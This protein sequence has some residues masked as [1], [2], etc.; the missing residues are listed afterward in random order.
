MN[1]DTWAFDTHAR[2]QDGRPSCLSL[3]LCHCHGR[4]THLGLIRGCGY[5]EP[6]GSAG[7]ATIVCGTEMWLRG[8]HVPFSPGKAKMCSLVSGVGLGSEPTLAIG[9]AHRSLREVAVAR[10]VELGSGELGLDGGS[11]KCSW[12]ERE[13]SAA[14]GHTAS[15]TSGTACTCPAQAPLVTSW[16][17]A[18]EQRRELRSEWVRLG[19]GGGC[20]SRCAETPGAWRAEAWARK[21]PGRGSE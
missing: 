9:H 20:P 18:S 3:T 4:R 17:W 21:R 13:Q 7:Q 10:M 1:P 6:C 19:R 12:S 2:L 8:L 15:Q 5:R 11:E 14:H 16:L